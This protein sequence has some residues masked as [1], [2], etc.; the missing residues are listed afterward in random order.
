M[1]TDHPAHSGA[2]AEARGPTAT[3]SGRWRIPFAVV[4]AV[5]LGVF[6]DVG[7]RVPGSLGLLPELGTPWL[8]LAFAGARLL[9]G[10]RR[11]V[12]TLFGCAL[13]LV[14]LLGY[15]AFVHLAYGVG[16]HNL[17]NDGRGVR[18]LLLAVGLGG[19]SA[20]AGELT[21]AGGELPRSAGW[22]YVAAVPVAEIGLV[23]SGA[24]PARA[25]L[26]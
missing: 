5:A 11:G 2:V 7:Q 17:V 10:R 21:R 9:R 1:T 3:S 16:Y 14:G 18:W 4:V 20:G 8:V 22:G 23:V 24:F 19:T 15:Y 26:S 25:G 12:A 6:A 13:V